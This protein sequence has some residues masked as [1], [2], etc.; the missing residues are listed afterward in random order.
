MERKKGVGSVN[1]EQIEQAAVFE[2][3]ASLHPHEAAELDWQKFVAFVRQRAGSKL[4]EAVIR[5][6]IPSALRGVS[7]FAIYKRTAN[8][9]THGDA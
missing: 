3:F 8:F 5:E 6:I 1:T 4:K 7:H 2:D 9:V